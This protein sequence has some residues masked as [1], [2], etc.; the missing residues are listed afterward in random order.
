MYSE[1]EI[2]ER[3]RRRWKLEV[4]LVSIIVFFSSLIGLKALGVPSY[5][6]PAPLLAVG[7]IAAAFGTCC[8][9]PFDLPRE[10][11]TRFAFI[12]GVVAGVWVWHTEQGN[13]IIGFLGIGAFTLLALIVS[14]ALLRNSSWGRFIFTRV[15]RGGLYVG[16]FIFFRN[17]ETKSPLFDI[18]LSRVLSRLTESFHEFRRTK[19]PAWEP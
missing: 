16:A 14:A 8:Y 6:S 10:L 18:F 15:I 1:T 3:M 7:V 5:F 12:G 11:F 19:N 4:V 9:V 17:G 13:L 2:R